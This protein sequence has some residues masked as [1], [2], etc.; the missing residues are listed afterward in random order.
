MSKSDYL[1]KK[2]LDLTLGGATFTPPSTIYVG[3]LTVYDANAEAGFVTE[4]STGQWLNYARQP[5]ANNLTNW[6]PAVITGGGPATSQTF[7]VNGNEVRYGTASIPGTG[8]VIAGFGLFDAP[9]GGNLLYS[10]ALL[11]SRVVTNGK[12]PVFPAGSLTVTED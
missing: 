11:V 8:I 6:P 9:T 5:L 1:E 4:V 12:K 10:G 2:Y 3:L 7:K